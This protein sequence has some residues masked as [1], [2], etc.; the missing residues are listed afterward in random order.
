MFVKIG[1]FVLISIVL[2]LQSQQMI[3]LAQSNLIREI[4]DQTALP[5]MDAGHANQTYQAGASKVSSVILYVV[6]LVK[7]IIGSI[8]TIIMVISGVKLV[9]VQQNAD[10][11][12]K[13]AKKNIRLAA[14]GLVTI[15][16]ADQLVKAIW[17]VEGETFR[18]SADMKQSAEN[19]NA[20]IGGFTNILRVIMPS[21]AVLFIVIAGAR[22]VT[23]RG[24]QEQLKKAKAQLTWAIGGLVL[25]GLVEVI[26]FQ[27]VFPNQG[28]RLSDVESFKRLVVTITNFVSGFIATIAVLLIIY[29]GYLYVISLGG[30]QAGKAKKILYAAIIGLIISMGAFAIVNTV[31]RIDTG[32]NQETVEIQNLAVPG[33][34]T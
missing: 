18:T 23:S 9:M 27:I 11:E 8:A 17:G 7:Y 1:L 13:K 25:A 19:I 6:D 22:L 2:V 4:G 30:D 14:F 20:L 5:S 34:S 26:V 32:G 24:D 12:M 33:Q 16:I 3:V 29:A 10:E 28:S 15:I 31:I 21:I